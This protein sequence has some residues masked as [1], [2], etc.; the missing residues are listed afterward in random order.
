MFINGSCPLNSLMELNDLLSLFK[1]CLVAF[2]YRFGR[3]IPFPSQTRNL[4]LKTHE[5]QIP[6]FDHLNIFFQGQQLA[7]QKYYSLLGVVVSTCL[8]KAKESLS[9]LVKQAFCE[10]LR[11]GSLKCQHSHHHNPL[12]SKSGV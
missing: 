1:G 2:K 6:L 12:G 8:E 5:E 10:G 4:H 3:L 9:S 11:W 7:T